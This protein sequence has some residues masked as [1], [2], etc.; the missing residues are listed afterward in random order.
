[1]ISLKLILIQQF[2]GHDQKKFYL[3]REY[4]ELLNIMF[5][6]QELQG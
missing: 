5:L 6:P 3:F 4:Y 1:M 2:L